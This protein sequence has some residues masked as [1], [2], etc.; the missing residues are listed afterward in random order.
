MLRRLKR[1]AILKLAARN[2]L[3]KVGNLFMLQF[4]LN[5]CECYHIQFLHLMRLG[6]T[7]K[8]K[9]LCVINTH[10]HW[11]NELHF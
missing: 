11:K 3:G 5:F 4:L 2:Y 1:Y 9:L 8:A 7:T 10:F 6:E